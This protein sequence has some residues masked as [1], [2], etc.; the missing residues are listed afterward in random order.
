MKRLCL[1]C[2]GYYDDQFDV[3]PHCGFIRGTPS[4]EA[5]H[6]EPGVVLRN[7][8]LIGKVLGSGGFGITYLG[9]DQTLDKKV[10]IKEYF[11]T[12]FATRMQSQTM[13]TV[14]SGE[15]EEQF[16]TGMKK[17]LDEARRLAEFQQTPGITQVF[18]FFEE[19][20]TAYIVME[21]LEGETLRE[22]LKRDGVMTVEDALPVVF[23]V[24]G[25]LKTVHAKEMIHRDI[26]PDNIYLLKNGEVKLLDFGASRQVTGTHS[27]SLT[28]MLKPGYAPVEQ[29][30]SGGD[31]GPWTDVYAL[32]ATFYKMITGKRPP[33]STERWTKDTL[34]EPS[35]LGIK[36]DRNLENAL[37]NALHV[38]QEDRTKSAQEF[39]EALNSTN[40]ARTQATVEKSDMGRWPLWV[41]VLGAAASVFVLVIVGLT[42]AGVLD[43]PFTMNGGLV[44]R[45]GTVWVPNLV[46]MSQA[47]AKN[48]A[49]ALGL[50]FQVG[51]TEASNT[52]MKGYVLDQ[53]DEKGNKVGPG[54]TLENGAVIQVTISSGNGKV[55]L[56]DVLW[57]N[58]EMALDQLEELGL[59]AVNEELDTETWAVKGTVTGVKMDG[60]LLKTDGEED[61]QV[62]E[63]AV[64]T[65]MVAEGTKA[66]DSTEQTVPEV[67][68]ISQEDGYKI[69][70]ENGF[71]LEKISYENNRET[72]K[73]E[74]LSQEPEAG[75]NVLND[76]V[77]KVYVSAGPKKV[78]LP[79]VVNM[80][81]NEARELLEGLGILVGPGN[82]VY[83]DTVEQGRVVSQSVASGEVA[84]GTE[85]VLEVSLGERPPET[86]RARTN[87]QQR[88]NNT[89]NQ[90]NQ[91]TQAPTAAPP[92]QT[93]APPPQT[94]APAPPPTQAPAPPPTTAAPANPFVDYWNDAVN[95]YQ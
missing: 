3:C 66:V 36:I 87:N 57:M 45:E 30:Q 29:Y 86:T 93:A 84:E 63:D 95:E 71:F 70:K 82:G 38:R 94:E 19:N 1:G 78:M 5:Y 79:D 11:P 80:E 22:K 64:L 58:Q 44:Q 20:N 15:K 61:V 56:P 69:L 59:V 68:G 47:D 50:K 25:A 67:K 9:Y 62:D 23:A 43:L 55:I 28:V 27:K 46:N 8:Y 48:R 33:D 2:M 65:L 76:R 73:G 89:T 24:L 35:K 10:A 18:D 40:V 14:F 41:K 37:M 42:V 31:Q 92:A 77:V 34:K 85:V 60:Q 91:G 75:K 54:D 51:G 26:A 12:E 7:R 74:I 88:N 53:T 32:A 17:S 81:E 72:P 16:V 39:E 90:R 83:S 6:M 21:F 13:V 52:V 4:Q 49:E